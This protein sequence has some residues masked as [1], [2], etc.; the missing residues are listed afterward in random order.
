MQLNG[1]FCF[2]KS[3]TFSLIPI[4][5]NSTSR[6]NLQKSDLQKDI[7]PNRINNIP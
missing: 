7:I 5:L 3:I 1:Q 6:A 2:P 4:K